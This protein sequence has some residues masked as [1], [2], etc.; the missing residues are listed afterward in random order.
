MSEDA[1]IK[2]LIAKE[3]VEHERDFSKLSEIKKCPRCDGQLDEGYTIITR[4]SAW[5]ESKPGFL[6]FAGLNK[7]L[8][9]AGWTRRAFPSVRCR[10]CHFVTFDYTSEV[11]RG[12]VKE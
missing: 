5:N 4:G 3:V 8:T 10:T 7:P 6:R 9:N 11:E 12:T 1:E 2:K